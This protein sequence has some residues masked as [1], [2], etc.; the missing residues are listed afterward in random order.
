MQRRIVGG[1]VLIAGLGALGL[2]ACSGE[3]VVD[4][5][6]TGTDSGTVETGSDAQVKETGSDATPDVAPDAPA[7]S[8]N[9]GI[10]NGTETDVDCGGSCTKTCDLTKACK[11]GKDCGS[12]YC[13]AGKCALARDCSQLLT[14]TPGL[15][16]GKYDVDLDG[17]GTLQPIKV[18]CDMTTEGGGWMLVLNYL[19]KA[20]TNPATTVLTTGLPV[21]GSTTLGTD[22]SAVAASWGHAGNA[23]MSTLQFDEMRFFGKTSNHAR[24]ID[25]VTSAPTAITYVRTGTGAMTQLYDP[26]YTRGLPGRVDA[27]LPLHIAPGDRQGFT[28]VADGAMT[29]FPF[30]GNSAIGNPR[31]HWAV[32]GLT[33]RWEVDDDLSA[34]NAG[35]TKDT[36]HQV[37]VRKTGC[38]DTVKNLGEADVDCGGTSA[39]GGCAATKAC[40][41]DSDCKSGT[42]TANACAATLATSCKT[43]LAAH[44]NIASGVY[45]IDPDGN[46]N[47][48]AIDAYCDMTFDSG[49][50][51]MVLSTAFGSDPAAS[52]AGPVLPRTTAHVPS[53][54]LTALAALSSQVHVRTHATQ[55][56]RSVTSKA[57]TAPITRLGA[58]GMLESGA[59]GPSNL[60]DWTGPFADNAHLQFTCTTFNGAYPSIYQSCGTNGMHL[61][62]G[63]GGHSRWNWLAGNR[64]LN[65]P[66]EVYVR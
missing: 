20:G 28:N 50:W 53:A 60:A 47:I 32:K 8:C 59:S 27:T 31:G 61:W 56:T 22:E 21:I 19:H 18:Q 24:V 3:T 38:G 45:T 54:T 48:P 1:A 7:P 11:S 63:Q 16:D 26:K 44:P 40:T 34:A 6:D 23:L 36:Y 39:C 52:V 64:S 17:P 57:A 49:G 35:P 13:S 41:K 5:P 15:P 43:L 65:E 42:C 51:T 37:W 33:N 46:G 4:V 12:S 29:E 10:L 58:L 25:F 2:I 30:F 55:G 66:M 62:T 14:G 9:D